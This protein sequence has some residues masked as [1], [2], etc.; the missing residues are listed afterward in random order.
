MQTAQAPTVPP[1]APPQPISPPPQFPA[2][3]VIPGFY[4]PPEGPPGGLRVE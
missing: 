2:A 3:P 1:A 4:M